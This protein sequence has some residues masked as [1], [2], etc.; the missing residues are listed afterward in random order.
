[1][2]PIY[3]DYNATTH[4]HSQVIETIARVLEE[5]WGNPSSSHEIG[6][7]AKAFFVQAKAGIA[8][9]LNA[10][11][12][13]IVLTSGG[14]EANNTVLTSIVE[15]LSFRGRHVIVSEIEHP[16]VLNPAIRLME[17]GFSVDF[18]KATSDCLV[19]SQEIARLLRPDTILVSVMLANNETGVIQPIKEIAQITRPLGILLHTDA[20]QAVGKIPVDVRSLSVDYLTVAGHKLYAPKGVGALFVRNG[21]PFSPFLLGGG[22]EQGRR[23]GTEAVALAAGLAC[24][25]GLAMQ[26]MRE[27]IQRQEQLR[28]RLWQGLKSIW[29]HLIR[30]GANQAVLPNTLSVSFVGLNASDLLAACP[31]L[32]VSTGAACHNLQDSSFVRISHVLS[33]MKVDSNVA[34]GTVRFSI[35]RMTDVTQIDTAIQLLSVGIKKA[36]GKGYLT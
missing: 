16:S 30:H 3:L 21:A 11:S 33:A 8:G 12:H 25:C 22:Q 28:E 34:Q 29:P 14:T 5:N 7:R 2:K 26:D 31:E 32:C 15:A 36:V 6:Q 23:S 9:L 27:E 1:M 17:R 10:A 18:A 20:A 19:T 35:G 24:A 13:E 4:S